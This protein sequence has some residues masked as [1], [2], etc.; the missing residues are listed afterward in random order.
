MYSFEGNY[1]SKRSLVFDHT[2]KLSTNALVQKTREERRLREN[3]LKQEGAAIKIQAYVRGYI[4]RNKRKRYFIELF[5]ELSNQLDYTTNKAA[6]KVVEDEYEHKLLKLLQFFNIYY[7]SKIADQQR[8]FTVCRLLLSKYGHD[9]QTSWLTNSS[10]DYVFTLSSSLL[11]IIRYLS[12]LPSLTKSAD[13]TLPIRVLEEVFTASAGLCSTTTISLYSKHVYIN[14]AL[15]CKYLSRH[16]YFKQIAYFIDQQL[17]LTAGYLQDHNTHEGIFDAVE[18]FKPPRTQAFINLLISP[19]KCTSSL[20]EINSQLSNSMVDLYKELVITALNDILISSTIDH[21]S[22]Y[23]ISER[24]IRSVGIELFKLPGLHQI[25]IDVCLSVLENKSSQ[26][27]TNERQQQRSSE[28]VSLIPSINLLHLLVT[29]VVPGMLNKSNLKST[30]SS[31]TIQTTSPP[32]IAPMT[33]DDDDED[34]GIIEEEGVDESLPVL[35][36][37]ESSYTHYTWCASPIEA[38]K[39][40]RCLAWMLMHCLAEPYLPII[41]PIVSPKALQL[42]IGQEEEFSSD[43]DDNDEVGGSAVEEKESNDQK[44]KT[45]IEFTRNPNDYSFTIERISFQP[46]WATQL[47]EICVGLRQSLPALVASALT[48]L[49]HFSSDL[50]DHNEVELIRSSAHLHYCLSQVYCLPRTSLIRINSIYSQHAIYLRC[51]WK[52]IENTKLSTVN[53]SSLYSLNS[54]CSLLNIL[55]S[56]DLPSRLMELQSYLPL[57]FTFADCLHHRLLCLTDSEICD[58][59][60]VVNFTT[61]TNDYQRHQ[62]VNEELSRYGCGFRADELLYVGAKL[63]D[64]MLGLIDIAHPDQLPNRIRCNLS[65][66]DSCYMAESL[67]QPNYGAVLRRIEQRVEVATLGTSP[68]AELLQRNYTG[69]SIADLRLL[70]YCWSSLF[71]RVQRLV[72]QIYDWDRRCRRRQDISLPVLTSQNSQFITTCT[73]SSPVLATDTV[74][75]IH[76]QLPLGTPSISQIFWLKDNLVDLLNTTTS[77]SWLIN[78]GD[79]TTLT[80]AGAPFGYYSILNPDRNQSSLT[81]SNREIRQVLLLKEV[82]FVIPFEKR[83]KLFQ[84]LI[85]GNTNHRRLDRMYNSLNQPE[86]FIVVR[87]NYLYEDAFERLSKENEP[88]LR[89]RLKVSFLNQAGLAEVG[90]DGGGLSREFLTE[91]IRAGFDPTRG[92]FIYASDKTLYPNPQASAI[93]SDYLKHYYFLGRILA[94][95]IYEGMLVELRFAYF[96]LAK[97]ISR[98]GGGVG[99]DYLHSLDP[100]LYKQLLFLKNYEGNVRDLS[101]DFTVVNSIFGQSETVELK[102]GGKYIPVTEENRVEYVHLIANYKLNKMIYP[103]VR[104]FTAGLNDVIPIDWL[105]LFDAEELQTLIS[106]ADMVIDVNDLKEHTICTGNALDYT[107]TLNIFW[108]VLQNFSESDKRLFLRFVTGCSRPPMFGFRDLQPPFSIQITN[109][110]DRLPTASTCM[111]LLRLPNFRNKEILRNRLLYALNAN[112]G[113]EYS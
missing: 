72:F 79:Q 21:H 46:V 93:T 99:F 62:S 90:I 3:L 23:P 28:T 13:Y 34:E 108:S 87:R 86:V 105:R 38:A 58:I 29:V 111:N 94:K 112:A 63:R 92:F 57:I 50:N 101:L 14:I 53:S 32:S 31:S 103:H 20:S 24:I 35:L 88:N 18:F 42:R 75:L 8:L 81:L 76:P 107:E 48:T 47:T 10:S 51:L 33:E 7:R 67:E 59:S 26:L 65:T 22:A 69:W 102:P 12:K 30:K 52:L 40:I 83:V 71:R 19:L 95:T 68:G 44:M 61:S 80:L 106:G 78:R 6:S 27:T 60:S 49:E 25:F 66:S 56:G 97:V 43:D 73:A 55:S 91:I 36:A 96:F 9:A 54:T 15:I 16:H 85:N 77:Q 4:V 2:Q 110:L 11:I 45:P 74:H 98:S 109:D 5:D 1:K 70:L 84:I 41:H 113:F 17:P 100:Q 89:P 37:T 64:L 82:P 104:A 39:V